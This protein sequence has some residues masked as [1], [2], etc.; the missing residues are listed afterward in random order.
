MGS[1]TSMK[2][3]LLAFEHAHSYVLAAIEGRRTDNVV[4]LAKADNPKNRLKAELLG[5][6]REHHAGS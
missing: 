3:G 1:M 4:R 6:L 5:R 2:D